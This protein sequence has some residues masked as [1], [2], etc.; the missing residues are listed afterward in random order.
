[1][2]S[3]CRDPVRD[4]VD[5]H[6]G[7]W[8]LIS[9]V[10]KESYG[11]PGPHNIDIQSSDPQTFLAAPASHTVGG[12]TGLR[13]WSGRI[14]GPPLLADTTQNLD[15]NMLLIQT[16]QFGPILIS[17]WGIRH[18]SVELLDGWWE[19]VSFVYRSTLHC[20]HW[21]KWYEKPYKGQVGVWC[22]LIVTII[23]V[24]SHH[25]PSPPPT[26]P[27]PPPSPPPPGCPSMARRRCCP[28]DGH[29]VL[30]LSLL[31]GDQLVSAF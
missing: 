30:A 4:A 22:G 25:H 1:M 20:T 17:G 5:Q 24:H 11:T 6:N 26:P 28:Q 19:T 7:N 27:S 16:D 31:A 23:I 15:P 18:F 8:Y 14:A 21:Y 2:R 29:Y 13:K 12:Q 3:A 10:I 9:H